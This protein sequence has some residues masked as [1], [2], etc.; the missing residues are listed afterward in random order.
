[1]RNLLF[2]ILCL[3]F[4]GVAGIKL[5]KASKGNAAFA[6]KNEKLNESYTV[7]CEDADHQNS[8]NYKL[9]QIINQLGYE[10]PLHL[11]AGDP[12]ASN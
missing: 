12:V 5:M 4:A 7:V 3:I 6:Q 9:R 10:V 11:L 8:Q 1:M 2:A